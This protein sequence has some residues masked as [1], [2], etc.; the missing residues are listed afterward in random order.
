M[1][2]RR[3]SARAR[4]SLAPPRDSLAPP[5]DSLA[6][7]RDSLAPPRDSNVKRAGEPLHSPAQVPAARHSRGRDSAFT[8]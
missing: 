2:A 3:A 1:T 5:R 8:I 7:P 6:P 4:D